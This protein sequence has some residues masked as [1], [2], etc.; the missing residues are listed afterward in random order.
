MDFYPAQ[1][2]VVSSGEFA[3]PIPLLLMPNTFDITPESVVR[4]RPEQLL[5]LLRND[6][7][8]DL[9]LAYCPL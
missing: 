3:N 2:M 7:R 1:A 6:V 9:E 4:L 5:D 8:H